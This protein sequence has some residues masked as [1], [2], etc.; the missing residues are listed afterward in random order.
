[1]KTTTYYDAS[2]NKWKKVTKDTNV[3]SV[4]TGEV[5]ASDLADLRTEADLD[6]YNCED[7]STVISKIYARVR[8]EESHGDTVESEIGDY[9]PEPL[10]V[11]DSY[12]LSSEDHGKLVVCKDLPTDIELTLPEEKKAGWVFAIVNRSGGRQEKV[13]IKDAASRI[14]RYNAANGTIGSLILKRNDKV[15]LVSDGDCWYEISST[16]AIYADND[17][18]GDNIADTYLR[19][20]SMDYIKSVTQNEDH[21]IDF[22]YSDGS[23]TTIDTVPNADKLTNPI[24]INGEVEFDGSKDITITEF[25]EG[26]HSAKTVLIDGEGS[27]LDVKGSEGINLYDGSIAI[28]MTTTEQ[29]ED[30]AEPTEV[31]KVTVTIDPTGT[32][33]ADKI[34]VDGQLDVTKDVSLQGDKVTVDHV[35]S[36]PNE[37][38][39]ADKGMV[40]KTTFFQHFFYSWVLLIT[41]RKDKCICILNSMSHIVLY[42]VDF[43]FSH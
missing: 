30:G 32:I 2:T 29:G 3:G 19:K 26:L 18:N 17:Q 35:L 5:T 13:T 34:T 38:I 23:K 24:T 9:K 11:S 42:I 27:S 10:I 4:S 15:V 8:N 12:A 43:S 33:T 1:M 22:G 36:V 31:S 21:S 6:L 41:S 40:V 16:Y 7:L 25:P 14:I 37:K 20:D 39:E 28:H